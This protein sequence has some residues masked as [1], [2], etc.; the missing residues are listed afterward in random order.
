MKR[1]IFAICVLVAAS[2]ACSLL[3]PTVSPTSNPPVQIQPTSN[4]A[5]PTAYVQPTAFVQPT[6]Q[7]P[8]QS[9][10]LFQDD[11]SSTSSGWDQVDQ[12]EKVTDYVNGGYRMWLTTVN[13][14]IW[15]NPNNNTFSGPVSVEVDA[16]LIAGPE[17][18]DFG[19]QCHYQDVSN[20]YVGLISSDG[21]AVIGKVQD[22]TSTY[23]SSDK[24][25]SVSGINSGNSTNHIKFVCNNG[26]LTLYANGNQVAYVYDTTFSGGLVGLQ[27]GTFDVGG[28]D[29]LFKNFVV[30]TP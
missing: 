8:P 25:T 14:D 3:S 2:L 20:F 15:A 27:V 6:V 28:V 13:Y 18:N 1:V 26:D 12:S 7:V 4:Q 16:T 21:Y 30:T 11:F 23:L 19:I 29:M 9:N 17:N 10:V 22:G 5:Q 24:M